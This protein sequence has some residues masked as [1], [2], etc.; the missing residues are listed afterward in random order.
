[1]TMQIAGKRNRSKSFFKHGH[2]IDIAIDAIDII[3]AII[4]RSGVT[5]YSGSRLG[6]LWAFIEPLILVAIFASLNVFLRNRLLFGES[7]LVFLLTGY[8]TLRIALTVAR[9]TMT[10]ITGGRALLTFPKISMMHLV[11]AQ[12]I[13]EV[14]TMA[15]VIILTYTLLSFLSDIAKVHDPFTF[16]AALCA[17][18]L[19]ASG[20]GTL[21]APLTV[22]WERI[23]RLFAF[24]S[25]PLI[26]CSGTFFIPALMDPR[27]LQ[28]LSW[29]PLLHC[30]EWFREA[31]YLDYVSVLDRSYA[32][33]C[34]FVFLVLGIILTRAVGLR[35]AT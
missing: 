15:I 35:G 24:V 2:W 12:V 10:S 23:P 26:F 6:Y 1:M 21:L 13:I 29:N 20:F 3:K 22:V 32:L 16:T 8:L 34:G 14:I 7:F 5:Q 19:L 30:V 25:L 9:R 17:T 11:F 33:N 18:L 31:I 28:F 27:V 4:L